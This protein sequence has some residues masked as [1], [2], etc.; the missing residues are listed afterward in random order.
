MSTL[1]RVLHWLGALL[2]LADVVRDTCA[3]WWRAATEPAWVRSVVQDIDSTV[4]SS[5][6]YDPEEPRP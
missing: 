5:A 3:L 4:P 6:F 1:R 2:A